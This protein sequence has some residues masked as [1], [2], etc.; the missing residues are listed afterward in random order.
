[1]I[2]SGITAQSAGGWV[3]RRLAGLLMCATAALFCVGGI[4]NAED[5]TPE[6]QAAKDSL[7]ALMS[8]K[9]AWHGPTSAPK[10]GHRQARGR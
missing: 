4:A 6:A 9:A 1:M 3:R 2:D 5:L 10:P 7:Q 8:E